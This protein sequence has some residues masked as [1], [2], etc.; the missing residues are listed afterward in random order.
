M[1]F[2]SERTTFSRDA[3]SSSGL[4]V[5]R[6]RMWADSLRRGMTEMMIIAAMNT[7]QAASAAT[8]PSCSTRTEEMITPT[9]PSVSANTWRNTPRGG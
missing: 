8:H 5:A 1:R 9:L 7:E 2:S 4:G 6:S 3:F